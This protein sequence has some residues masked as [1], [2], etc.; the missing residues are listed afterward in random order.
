MALLLRHSSIKSGKRD[1]RKS[2]KKPPHRNIG[3]KPLRQTWAGR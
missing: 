1:R 2:R 3:N